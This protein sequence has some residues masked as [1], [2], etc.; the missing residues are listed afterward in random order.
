MYIIKN[1]YN[2]KITI[3]KKKINNPYYKY[4]SWKLN[5]VKN[6]DIILSSKFNNN[7]INLDINFKN[8]IINLNININNLD[9]YLNKKNIELEKIIIINHNKST[10]I[11]SFIDNILNDISNY[12]E[13]YDNNLDENDKKNDN[14]DEDEENE[15]SY[16]SDNNPF[17]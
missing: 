8:N 13:L 17:Q 9:Y 16:E 14:K 6:S 2:K 3:Y 5:L 7:F 1:V 15:Y 11:E 12:N 4:I 10:N